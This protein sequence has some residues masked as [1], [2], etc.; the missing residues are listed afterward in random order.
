ML[1]VHLQT[2][3]GVHR[4]EQG[5][6]EQAPVFVFPQADDALGI[7]GDQGVPE[8]PHDVADVQVAGAV[9]ARPRA[10]QEIMHRFEVALV[11]V[12]T[13]WNDP[14]GNLLTRY[15]AGQREVGPCV[16]IRAVPIVS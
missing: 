1:R 5:E 16:G 13:R 14:T 9:S 11:P 2:E 6:A 15:G 3:P 12:W 4:I 8:A 10:H 7:V